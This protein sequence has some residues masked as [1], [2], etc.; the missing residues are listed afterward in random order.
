M[1]RRLTNE[2]TDNTLV[3]AHLLQHPSRKWPIQLLPSPA[4]IIAHS[5]QQHNI[6]NV[7]SFVCK[8]DIGVPCTSIIHAVGAIIIPWLVL[9]TI[10]FSDTGSINTCI[11]KPNKG[12]YGQRG[13]SD[14]S[15]RI[16][17][18]KSCCVWP[19]V[20]NTV[21]LLPQAASGSSLVSYR[22]I[23]R[24]TKREGVPWQSHLEIVPSVKL[25]LKKNPPK[26][27]FFLKNLPNSHA[28]NI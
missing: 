28:G 20:N 16:K 11:V 14:T 9:I 8:Y 1:K 22:G 26:M 7:N 13:N 18:Q 24:T 25:Q 2:E 21:K 15:F 4:I 23:V 27:R 12:D 17:Q 5:K 10:P 6:N 19:S 3:Q